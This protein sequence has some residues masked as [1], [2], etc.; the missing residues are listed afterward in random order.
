MTSWHP[1]SP[2][3]H[4]CSGSLLARCERNPLVTGGFPSQRASDT[5]KGLPWHNVSWTKSGIWSYVVLFPLLSRLRRF[6]LRVPLKTAQ[7]RTSSRTYIPSNGAKCNHEKLVQRK[8]H[9]PYQISTKILTVGMLQLPNC[10]DKSRNLLD[11]FETKKLAIINQKH[12]KMMGCLRTNDDKYVSKQRLLLCSSGWTRKLI[13]RF[14]WL[15]AM[16]KLS[17]ISHAKNV[18]EVE[19]RTNHTNLMTVHILDEGHWWML[20]TKYWTSFQR[21]CS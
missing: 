17:P 9:L 11:N 8:I 16:D 3:T 13:F 10:R 18:W 12:H 15:D 5:E 20:V 1:M 6:N 7:F 2:A 19:P 21:S 14:L 4:V